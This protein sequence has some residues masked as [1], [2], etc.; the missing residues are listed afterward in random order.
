[1]NKEK[2]KKEQKT[3]N[4]LL[5]DRIVGILNVNNVW[6]TLNQN[7]ELDLVCYIDELRNV[8]KNIN[9]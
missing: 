5:V 7:D 3:F 9:V 2:L 8:V 4:E 6:K 1:M